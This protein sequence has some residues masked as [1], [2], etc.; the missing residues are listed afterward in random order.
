M[1]ED[2]GVVMIVAGLKRR[3]RGPFRGGTPK[4]VFQTI[5]VG[6]GIGGRLPD[7]ADKFKARK[8]AA[9]DPKYGSI[10][11]AARFRDNIH[12][13]KQEWKLQQ[14][15]DQGITLIPEGIK[16]T[17]KK[18]LERGVKARHINIDMP[19]Y[20][21][22]KYFFDEQFM[23]GLNKLL[24][25]N[26]KIFLTTETRETGESLGFNA[27]KAGFS[28]RELKPIRVGQERRA[29]IRTDT[30]RL[31]QSPFNKLTP[32]DE[33]ARTF[34]R[35]ELTK[36]LKKAIPNKAERRKWPNGGR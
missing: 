25:P 24:L 27:K 10:S 36:S 16:P 29:A 3:G 17:V 4:N 19:E 13:R 18:L 21:I 8:Y 14:M 15:R 33:P 20:G 12:A 7:Q 11:E 9:V 30:M 2:F 22:G 28:Y 32:S 5:S 26:G 6:E 31:L 34:Y 35:F 23:L 1:E